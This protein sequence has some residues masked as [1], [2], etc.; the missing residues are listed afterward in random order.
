MPATP[1]SRLIWA[2]LLIFVFFAPALHAQQSHPAIDAL[3]SDYAS[4]NVPGCALGVI[5]NGDW[6]YRKAYGKANLEYDLPLTTQSIFDTA[7]VGKQFTAVAVAL[8]AE[9][10]QISMDDSLAK[11]FPEFPGWAADITIEQ[12][13]FHTSGIRD[14]LQLAYLAG[15][16]SDADNYTDQW[17]IDAMARQQETNFPP[18][19]EFLYSNSGYLLLAHLVKRVTGQTLREYGKEHIFGPLGMERTG[20][21]D[22]HTRLVPLRAYGYAPDEDGF[23]ISMSTLDMVGDGGVF[24]SVDELFAWDQNFYQNRLG[25]GGPELIT[26]L[27][28]PANLKDGTAITYAYGL[29]VDQYRGQKT[30]SHS[31]SWVGYRAMIQRF[32]D[33]KLS[34][35]VLCNRA[36][37]D[38]GTLALKVSDLLLADVLE[39]KASVTELPDFAMNVKELEKFA[40]DFWEADEALAAESRVI[41]GELW[42]VHSP[43]EKNVL[44]PVAANRFQMM[45]VPSE[46][47]VE[48]DMEGDRPK[49]LRRFINGEASGVFT[50]FDRLQLDPAELAEYEGEYYSPELDTVYILELDEGKLW[51]SLEKV[52][53]RS[54]REAGLGHDE[55][56]QELTAMF[57]E[58]FENPAYGAFTFTRNTAGEVEG[59]T[60]QSGRVR[61]LAFVRQ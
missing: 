12:L 57:G 4:G 18:G 5:E 42:A 47:L 41:D 52:R 17:A 51:F 48:F 8:L 34:V 61:N 16:G 13:V 21:I 46:V 53:P 9:S 25:K 23:R 43:A 24:T 32:P 10:G 14:Y 26:R 28:T 37:A 44:R 39:P 27:T 40:G 59:F 11:Y 7:S 15:K 33:L 22:D 35:I 38:P 6:V 55:G 2:T 31:G 1:H 20:Y 30:V 60:L 50:P 58:T 36:D 45:G 49:V 3:F 56:P 29:D 19:T 54:G